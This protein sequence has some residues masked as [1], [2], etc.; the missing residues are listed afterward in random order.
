MLLL[1]CRPPRPHISSEKKL[2]VAG[3]QR[4]KCAGDRTRC[5]MWRL[6]E[7]SVQQGSFDESGFEIAHTPPWRVAHR[8]DRSVLQALCHSCHAFK[9]RMERIAGLEERGEGTEYEEAEYG[10]HTATGASV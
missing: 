10:A 1:K 8:S 4:F 7:G 9:T 3:A 6:N 2:L 5:P